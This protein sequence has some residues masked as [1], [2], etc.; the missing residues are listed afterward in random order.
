MFGYEYEIVKEFPNCFLDYQEHYDKN[1][2]WS[3]RIVSSSGD[4]SGNVYDFYFKVYNKLTQDIK[5]PFKLDGGDRIDDTPKKMVDD[6]LL[7]T[8]GSKKNRTGDFSNCALY[9]NCS[10]LP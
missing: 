1:L 2:R 6:E 4:W 9:K 3:D 10:A 8:N 5:V 7:E